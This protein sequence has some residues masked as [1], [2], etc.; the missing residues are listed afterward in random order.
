MKGAQ[1]AMECEAPRFQASSPPAKAVSAEN[2]SQS[3]RRRREKRLRSVC[4]SRARH[5]QARRL[6]RPATRLRALTAARG[7][8]FGIGAVKAVLRASP[9]AEV[10]T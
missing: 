10:R 1:V 9:S 2:L 3:V 7:R 4:L 8:E 5:R 6:R